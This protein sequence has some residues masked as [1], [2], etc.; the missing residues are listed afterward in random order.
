M[1]EIK[2]GNK[3]IEV[4]YSNYAFRRM[5]KAL[6]IPLAKLGAKMA[7][8]EI[9]IND[10]TIMLWAG[11]LFYNEEAQLDDADEIIDA[12]GYDKISEVINEA[13]SDYFPKTEADS[14]KNA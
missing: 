10:I 7:N 2:I 13:M 4:K 11:L 12:V 5:E 9:G 8:N 1:A 6:G 3:S 14:E